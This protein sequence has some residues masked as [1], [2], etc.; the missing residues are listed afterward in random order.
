MLQQVRQAV[1][2]A[3]LLLTVL[4]FHHAAK[5]EVRL[6]TIGEAHTAPL[7]RADRCG[8]SARSGDRF[9]GWKNSYFLQ[10]ATGAISVDRQEDTPVQVGDEVEV[11]GQ[12]QPGLFANILLSGQTKVMGH[13]GLPLGREAT[14]RELLTGQFDST[15]VRVAGTVR[16]SRTG[17]IWGK[18]RPFLDLQTDDAVITVYLP[19]ETNGD[20][21]SLVDSQVRIS[22]VCGTIFNSRR[23][24][25]GLRLEFVGIARAD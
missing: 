22:G 19:N 20:L 14:Y 21:G 23:Q 10:D 24:L 5:S 15:L 6:R 1:R 16:A 4:F 17:S 13:R 2:S 7:S 9:L 3:P 12:L 11:T 18:S 25:I 8:A